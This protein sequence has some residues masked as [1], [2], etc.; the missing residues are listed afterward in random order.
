MRSDPSVRIVSAGV[1]A[2]CFDATGGAP[3]SPVT[4]LGT[5]DGLVCLLSPTATSAHGRGG[6][7][8]QVPAPGAVTKPAHRAVT[9]PAPG[10]VT[11]PAPGAVTKPAPGAVTKPAPEAVT[12]PVIVAL[13]AAAVERRVAWVQEG[14]GKALSAVS[15]APTER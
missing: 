2:S 7:A 4:C 12:K 5:L 9:K 15:A 11:K 10:A 13:A 1:E 8:D 3:S 6:R 14:S